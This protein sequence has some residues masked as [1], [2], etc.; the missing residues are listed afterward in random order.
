VGR[1]TCGSIEVRPGGTLRVYTGYDP[2]TGKWHHI[3][4]SVPPGPRA[5]VEAEKGGP[6]C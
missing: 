1:S 5:R 2:V 3:A 6:D 4:E